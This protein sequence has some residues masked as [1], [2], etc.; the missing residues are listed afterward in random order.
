[1]TTD[2]DPLEP[3]RA[4]FPV[5]S[6]DVDAFGLLAGPALAGFLQEV[7]GRH[8]EALGVGVEAL[9]ARGL[10]W[11]LGRSRIELLR[12]IRLGDLVAVDTWPSG[13][14]RVAALRDFRV[15]NQA[16]EEVARAVTSWLVMDLATRRPVRPERVLEE[17]LRRER[18]HLLPPPAAPL[19]APG[20]PE[21]ERRF[22]IRYQDIDRNLHATNASYLAWA[23]EAIPE[24]TWRG[25]RLAAIE[26]HFL[27]E[28][29]H[30][31]RVLSRAA[32]EGEGTFL[33]AVVRE[34]DGRELCRL[35]TRWT[36][37]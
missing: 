24:A 1:V 4:S 35:R 23:L 31:S 32:R 22:H 33:H 30:G 6:F 26:A 34:E 15:R 10:A 27:A 5:H 18:E 29:R 17:R 20:A 28:C 8:A 2:A 13:V 21:V 16:G 7:A 36:A 3:L 11:V 19:P 14:D 37:R 12:P 25:D 9:A